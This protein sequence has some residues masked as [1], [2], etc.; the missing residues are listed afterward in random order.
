MRTYDEALAAARDE[1]T[2]SNSSQW[3][4][5][6]AKNCDRCIHDRP[7]RQGDDGNGCPL[8]LISLLG[9]R[10][11][12]WQTQSAEDDVFADYTCTEFRHDDAPAPQARPVS[13]SPGQG[14]LLPCEPYEVR[15]TVTPRPP[16][17]PAAAEGGGVL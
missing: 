8:I 1:S 12:E 7:A 6:S 15:C 4:V 3:E 5:W 13:V 17:G 11:A 2:F 14:E 16:S 9:K 10:P